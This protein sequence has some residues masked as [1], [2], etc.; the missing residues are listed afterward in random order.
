MLH[1][2]F[3]INLQA[4]QQAP[5]TKKVRISV[6]EGV[7]QRSKPF[8]KLLFNRPPPPFT[9]HTCDFH[10]WGFEMEYFIIRQ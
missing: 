5:D 3:L 1:R 9:F 8:K 7:F 4:N 6:R 10:F 2:S